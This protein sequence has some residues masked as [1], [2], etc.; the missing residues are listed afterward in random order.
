MST[1]TTTISKHNDGKVSAY[2]PETVESL[3]KYE[4][5][6]GQAQKFLGNL[7]FSLSNAQVI[8]IAVL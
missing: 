4:T 1:S 5:T 2:E 8:Y 6:S 3:R 7:K